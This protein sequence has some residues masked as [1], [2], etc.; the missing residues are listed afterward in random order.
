MLNA[1][2]LQ[3]SQKRLSFNDYL[4]LLLEKCQKLILTFI[5]TKNNA[6]SL[7]F[8]NLMVLLSRIAF[9]FDKH[10][11]LT[12]FVLNLQG[13]IAQFAN[14][15]KA[16]KRPLTTTSHWIFHSFKK[17]KLVRSCFIFFRF[18]GFLLLSI[19]FIDSLSS[20]LNKT[21]TFQ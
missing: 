18:I 21:N 13:P 11:I 4:M 7:S 10:L 17:T 6:N 3:I 1:F 2:L 9:R 14:V 16:I 5:F 19:F 15:L 8:L 20:L 12:L